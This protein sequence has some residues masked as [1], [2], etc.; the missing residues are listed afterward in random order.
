MASMQAPATHELRHFR[1]IRPLDH[2]LFGDDRV[3]QVGRRHVEHRI[4][5]M[6]LGG[7]A[8]A[9]DVQQLAAIALLDR[10]VFTIF[11]AHVDG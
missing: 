4:D 1:C 6:H 10:D 2:A 11:Q 3:D 5:R 9:A 7:D 8:L